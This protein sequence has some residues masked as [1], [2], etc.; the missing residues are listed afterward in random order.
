MNAVSPREE[1]PVGKIKAT[2]EIKGG[3][4]TGLKDDFRVPVGVELTVDVGNR[5]NFDLKNDTSLSGTPKYNLIV[6]GDLILDGSGSNNFNVQPSGDVI[7]NGSLTIATGDKITVED[8]QALEIADLTKFTGAG[9]IVRKTDQDL[10]IDGKEYKLTTAATGLVGTNS[11]TTAGVIADVESAFANTISLDSN[12]FESIA[13]SA[14][15]VAGTVD[16]IANATATNAKKAAIPTGAASDLELPANV[17]VSVATVVA[18]PGPV[19]GSLTPVDFE[20]S[21]KVTDVQITDKGGVP[22]TGGTPAFGIVRFDNIGLSDSTG[23]LE[24]VHDPDGD[25]VL[26][27]IRTKRP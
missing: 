17:S 1:A 14:P 15:R 8:G 22:V 27:A 20:L 25:G 9:S 24:W 23:N 7:I 21:L 3:S 12:F 18:S 2:G 16:I 13:T 11:G 5:A 4:G 10:K 19:G 6:E 26:I